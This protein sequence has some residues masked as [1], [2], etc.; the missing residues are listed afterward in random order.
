M[1][2]ESISLH[3]WSEG[4]GGFDLLSKER[5]RYQYSSLKKRE[6]VESG[7]FSC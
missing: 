7:K 2:S 1:L 3:G 5:T 6:G 4:K